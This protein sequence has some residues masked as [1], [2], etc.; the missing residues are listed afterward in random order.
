MATTRRAAN[1]RPEPEPHANHISQLELVDLFHRRAVHELV[2]VE[3]SPLFYQL[4]AIISWR[5]GRWTLMG[6]RGP[7]NFRSLETL[8]RHLKTIGAGSTII[9]LELLT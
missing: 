5:S 6:A 8:A 1:T 3:I 2:I 7:R 9:R 4:E